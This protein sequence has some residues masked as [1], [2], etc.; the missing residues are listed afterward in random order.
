MDGEKTIDL[1]DGAFDI[2]AILTPDNITDKIESVTWDSSEEKVATVEG[3]GLD[4]T[5]T[6]VASGTTKISVKVTTDAG[7]EFSAECEIRVV[8]PMTG[9][10]VVQEGTDVTGTTIAL[11]K[12][13][14][15]ELSYKADPENTTDVISSVTWKS[16]NPETVSVEQNGAEATVTTIKESEKPIRITVTAE[17]TNGIEL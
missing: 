1:K 14:K 15:A 12:G 7:T 13:E 9:I 2:Q 10:K 3:E 8:I 11:L 6:P 16:E 17:L 5:V 4:A